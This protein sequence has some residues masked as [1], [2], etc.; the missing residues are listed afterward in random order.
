MRRIAKAL[1]R[2]RYLGSGKGL[3]SAG[4]GSELISERSKSDRLSGSA[5]R[6]SVRPYVSRAH[7]I[8]DHFPTRRVAERILSIVWATKEHGQYSPKPSGV[9]TFIYSLPPSANWTKQCLVQLFCD[10]FTKPISN[11]SLLQKDAE[12]ATASSEHKSTQNQQT[13]HRH[14]SKIRKG[15]EE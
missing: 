3:R 6:T 10:F 2:P 11:A 7:C 12:S 9:R 4:L 13:V 8:L 5:D 1:S 14:N 15:S